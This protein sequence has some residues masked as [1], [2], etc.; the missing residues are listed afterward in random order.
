M[1]SLP[2]P[3][4]LRVLL[5]DSTYNYNGER[6]ITIDFG[7]V[8]TRLQAIEQAF[9][10]GCRRIAAAVTANGVSTSDNAG[11]STIVT[12]IG[13]I[14]EDG[15]A[16]AGQILTGYNAWVNKQKVNGSMPNRG[17]VTLTPTGDNTATG[18]AGYYSQVIANGRTSYAA[19][20]TKGHDDV[21]QSPGSYGLYTAAQYSANRTAG[22]NDVL[23]HPGDYD[24]YTEAQYDANYAAGYA[25]GSGAI[26][27]SRTISLTGSVDTRGNGNTAEIATNCNV[28]VGIIATSAGIAI[29][30]VTGGI[31]TTGYAFE[32]DHYSDSG[33]GSFTPS[34]SI[35]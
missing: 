32:D 12:N 4:P 24:L 9:P 25:A 27:M 28:S 17:N 7:R 29:T 11:V 2:N 14:R 5:E 30:G 6:M 3:Y 34:A 21:T 26:S 33:S 10:D 22:R 16:G 15:N 23:N 20:L 8:L 31:L 35:S 1:T 19:G 18:E 13:K